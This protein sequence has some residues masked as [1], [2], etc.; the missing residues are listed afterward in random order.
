MDPVKA[1]G[2]T[3][4]LGGFVNKFDGGVEIL[5]DLDDHWTAKHHKDERNWLIGQLQELAAEKS[6]RV[7]ILSGDVHLAA[8]GQFYSNKKQDVPKHCDYRYIPNVISSAIVNTPPPDVMADAINKRNKVHHLNAFTDED[9]IAIFKKDVDGK[10]RNNM[11]LLPRRNWCSLREY[12]PGTTPPV[13][14]SASPPNARDGTQDGPRLSRTLSDYT[15]GK[16]V[17]RL[18]RSE[19]GPPMAYLNNPAYASASAT[20]PGRSRRGSISS[21][22]RRR[23]SLDLGDGAPGSSQSMPSAAQR[24]GYSSRPVTGDEASP[25]ASSAA[26]PAHMFHR[27][28][29]LTEKDRRKSKRDPGLVDLESGLDVCLNMEVSQ[30]DPAGITAPY[31][32]LVP[33]LTYEKPESETEEQGRRKSR[34]GSIFSVFGSKVPRKPVGADGYSHTEGSDEE[35]IADESPAV[36]AIGRNGSFPVGPRSTAAPTS[37]ANAQPRNSF[38]YAPTA[39]TYTHNAT[40]ALPPLSRTPSPSRPPTKPRRLSMTG[41]LRRDRH[42]DRGAA[43]PTHMTHSAT[44][45]NTQLN[46]NPNPSPNS[47]TTAARPVYPPHPAI[48]GGVGG[49]RYYGGGREGFSDDSETDDENDYDDERRRRR[50]GGSES[51]TSFVAPKRKKWWSLG[52]RT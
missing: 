48:V 16:L 8:V 4:A 41:I 31:R 38:S 49:G 46:S 27:R 9:M 50:A 43:P 32:I 34:M 17:R 39:Q 12:K 44:L 20:D 52:R 11:H 45:A 19:R 25:K 42:P 13:S 23:T 21:L 40:Q 36:A 2:R 24:N 3:G 28:P 35:S 33:A 14:R 29:T 51:D 7:T 6:V 5:D 1:I 30:R 22:F 26:L 10:N 15:P 18:S 37:A 47:P